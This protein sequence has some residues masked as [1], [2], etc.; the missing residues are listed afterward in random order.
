MLV[1][2]NLLRR[3]LGHLTTCLQRSARISPT[4]TK[5]EWPTVGSG[6]SKIRRVLYFLWY[7]CDLMFFMC[8]MSIPVT[9]SGHLSVPRS[10]WTYLEKSKLSLFKGTNERKATVENWSLWHPSLYLIFILWGRNKLPSTLN[11]LLL[12]LIIK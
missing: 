11:I 1:P 6:L 10:F 12:G 5:R 7:F 9:I 3:V 4:T 2:Q 8:E